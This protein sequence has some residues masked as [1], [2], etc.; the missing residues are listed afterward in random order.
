M[1]NVEG[2]YFCERTGILIATSN[3]VLSKQIRK[4]LKTCPKPIFQDVIHFMKAE[5]FCRMRRNY[6]NVH[7]K[8][9]VL[10]FPFTKYPFKTHSV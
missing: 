9:A 5:A 7:I 8:I 6:I 4:L 1:D 3:Y 2:L 10:L